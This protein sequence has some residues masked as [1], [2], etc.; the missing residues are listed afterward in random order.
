MILNGIQVSVSHYEVRIDRLVIHIGAGIQPG[1]LEEL[2]GTAIG[3]D[4]LLTFSA[5]SRSGAV[6]AAA[7]GLTGVTRGLT[8]VIRGLTGAARGSSAAAA[9][10]QSKYHSQTEQQAKRSL[11]MLFHFVLLS[12]F[13]SLTGLD[14]ILAILHKSSP[15]SSLLTCAYFTPIKSNF[16][17]YIFMKISSIFCVYK[18][19]FQNPSFSCC[20]PCLSTLYFKRKLLI[21]GCKMNV[22]EIS[23]CKADIISQIVSARCSLLR[24]P[25]DGRFAGSLFRPAPD[26]PDS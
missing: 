18:R 16:Q 13:G 6:T 2:S 23:M 22:M 25:A 21:S 3:V 14:V 26:T 4:D 7:S 5:G 9:R 24:D 19:T 12:F 15:P 20:Q 11:Q 10:S 17:L 1:S 8:G